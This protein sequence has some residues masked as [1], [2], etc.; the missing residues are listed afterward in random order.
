M[1]N[2]RAPGT[3]H[4]HFF[5]APTRFTV[6]P[7]SP[8]AF[9]QP[10]SLPRLPAAQVDDAVSCTR[11]QKVCAKTRY[12]IETTL[13]P[14]VG[15]VA[16][17]HALQLARFLEHHHISEHT[18]Q[19]YR[20]ARDFVRR[21]Y[22]QRGALQ[23]MRS[24]RTSGTEAFHSS[25]DEGNATSGY[26]RRHQ[27]GGNGESGFQRSELDRYPVLL[28]SGCGTGRSSIYLARRRPDLPVL[29]IDRSAVRLRGRHS[30]EKAG[31]Q[32][33]Q[34][35]SRE[36][37]M[38]R[39]REERDEWGVEEREEQSWRKPAGHRHTQSF[40]GEHSEC[41]T[42]L[43]LLRADLVDLWILA[44][45]DREWDILEH[46]ILYPNPYPKRSQLRKR[47]HGHPVFPILLCLG[48]IITLRSNWRAYLDETCQAVLAISA[49]TDNLWVQSFGRRTNSTAT[50]GATLEE[51]KEERSS[52]KLMNTVG[53]RARQSAISCSN[54][55]DR[56]H[57]R[58]A[59]QS[60]PNAPYSRSTGRQ[61]LSL[62]PAS[63][64][65][66]FSESDARGDICQ[67]AAVR[68]TVTQEYLPDV[69]YC[70]ASYVGS[71]QRGAT[72]HTPDAPLSNFEAKYLAVGEPVFEVVLEPA[73]RCFK[74]STWSH[75]AST[76]LDD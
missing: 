55:R 15:D 10:R 76:A 51:E 49:V 73:Q 31:Q 24:D 63:R 68:Q 58:A 22:Y 13:H 67:S 6:E 8:S 57:A 50:A 53:V 45:E 30:G 48:G 35:V 75:E 42:N 52:R 72:L 19:A 37:G 70:A 40:G 12:S 74:E 47:W 65:T 61:A 71:A 64:E 4:R 20:Q 32:H 17:K 66:R 54:D 62:C 21:F 29:G 59:T 25:G 5:A 27:E 69:L 1:N 33:R 7:A 41:P 38:M 18:R 36:A 26:I 56:H 16:V 3:W 44:W 23:Q 46:F 9:V 39:W 14:D 2:E 34:P 28:D 11:K 43:L 60:L